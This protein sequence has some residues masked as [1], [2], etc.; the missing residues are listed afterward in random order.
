[1]KLKIKDI[2]DY[3]LSKYPLENAEVWDP[4]GFSYKN[5]INSTLKGV[6]LAIDLTNE[7]LQKAIDNDCNLIIT[8]HPFL[9]E[10]TLE[11]EFY[12]APYKKEILEKLKQN[13]ITAISFHT[14]YD[15][16]AYGTSYQ[17]AKMLK[18]QNYVCFKD[19]GYPVTLFTNTNLS[20]VINSFKTNMNL[21]QFRTNIPVSKMDSPIQRIAILSGSG[22]IGEIIEFAKK[23]YDLI[24]SSDIKWSDW[25]VYD[26]IKAPI[27]EVP[28][29]DEEAFVYDFYQQLKQKFNIKNVHICTLKEPY[30]NL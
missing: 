29:L 30:R 15:N 22:Y 26:Q 12:K 8:H 13:K 19:H 6:V 23:G 25:I 17:I 28:H 3:F 24:I 5:R 11:N 10:K 2:T 9:F 7:V 20:T 21:T 16:D 1:M 14:N 18:L 4:S 27:L